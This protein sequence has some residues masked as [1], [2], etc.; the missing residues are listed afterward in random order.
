ARRS[1]AGGGRPAHGRAA[2][3]SAGLWRARYAADRSIV[4]AQ[5]RI[6]DASYT[7]AGVLP[8][9]F[10]FPGNDDAW[11]P[12]ALPPERFREDQRGSH[13]LRVL[14]RLR[15]EVTLAQ[16]QADFDRIGERLRALHPDDYRGDSGFNPLVVG[17]LDHV[18]GDVRPSLWL[19][20]GA[21][22]LVLLIAC[23]NVAN[24]LLARGASRAREMSLRAALGAG[25]ARL[26]RQLLTESVALAFVGG[27]AGFL[28]ALWGV[29]LLLALAPSSLPR[30]DEI[31]VDGWV[32]G[33]SIGLTAV[34]GIAF[35]LLP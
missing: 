33:F 26:V 3:L 24:L 10:T 12:L 1:P 14:G 7:V 5:L 18:V 17:L 19:L 30:T 4:G 9:G 32:L 35:G 25:R 34:T 27:L 28:V 6:D 20:V 29:D 23:A 8:A 15:P 13:Y 21:A 11:V 22:A 2:P 31:A 16:A